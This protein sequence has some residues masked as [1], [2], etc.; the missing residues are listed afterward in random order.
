MITVT[1]LT[2]YLF[3]AFRDTNADETRFGGG[4]AMFESVLN[5]GNEDKWGNKCLAVRLDIE[6]SS[7]FYVRR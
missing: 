1:D 2:N 3:V 6:L 5:Q 7:H 4:D